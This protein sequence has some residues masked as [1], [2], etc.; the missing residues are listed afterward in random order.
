[1]A[2][3]TCRMRRL[4]LA[5]IVGAVFEGGC[6]TTAAL[7]V[8]SAHEIQ[9]VY[10]EVQLSG[11]TLHRYGTTRWVVRPGRHLEDTPDRWISVP[12]DSLTW[13]ALDRLGT[14]TPD[15]ELRG[16]CSLTPSTPEPTPTIQL[17][18]YTTWPFKRWYSPDAPD[19]NAPL[20]V[21]VDPN[22]RRRLVFVKVSSSDGQRFV[23]GVFLVRP[24]DYD[25]PW[26]RSARIAL[27]P[28]AV[29]ADVITSPFQAFLL[30]FYAAAG[31]GH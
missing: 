20:A 7:K 15:R 6:V 30:M 27:V 10:H 12:L 28:F 29:V 21:Y 9:T 31:T 23:S 19:Y 1:M 14:T 26:A 16:D 18:D 2:A 8:G 25:L 5:T 24:C 13:I 11:T 3:G 17:H 22:D 4:I